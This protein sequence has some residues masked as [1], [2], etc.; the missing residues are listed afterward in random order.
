LLVRIVAIALGAWHGEL[1]LAVMLFATASVLCWVGFLAWIAL[2]TG[3][4]PGMILRPA[5]SA[6]AV[7]LAAVFPLWLGT[8]WPVL[9]GVW[10][11]SV[12]ATAGLILTH[13]WRQFRKAY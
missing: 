10:W 2:I 4:T 7:S 8:H 5:G 6:L 13:Y 11:S 1:I 3:N 12:A 9:S